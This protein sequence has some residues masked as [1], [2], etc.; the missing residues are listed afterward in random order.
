MTGLITNSLA[1]RLPNRLGCAQ[2]Y[3][4]HVHYWDRQQQAIRW[5]TELTGII[6]IT[7]ERVLDDFS[8]AR[9]KFKPNQGD[10]C[11]GKI[12]PI[13]NRA[14]QLVS[15]GL[16]PWAH[17]LS[18]YR[19]GEL[20]WQG[21]LFSIDELIMPDEATESITLVARDFIGWLDRRVVHNDLW[22]NNNP[23]H[24]LGT[25]DLVEIAEAIVRDAFGPDDPGVLAHLVTVLSGRRSKRTIRKWE[26]RSGDELRDI[27]RTGLDITCVGRAIKIKG[28]RRDETETTKTLR[29]QDFRSGIEIRVIGSEAATA[30]VTVG[31]VETSGDPNAPI[32]DIPPAKAYVTD[33]NRPAVDPFFGLIENWTQQEG[34]LDVGYLEWIGRQKI[35]EGYPP[36][37]TLSV[38]TDSGLSPEA[39]V[40]IHHL[41]PGTFFTILVQG[42]CRSLAQYMRLSHVRV[43][44]TASSAEQVGVTFIPGVLNEDIAEGTF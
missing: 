18:I 29:A 19:D 2:G 5:Y 41:V 39:P 9:V 33:P 13:L 14:G 8:E 42:T 4:V 17:E 1:E 44:W 25:Y 28:A 36:P 32:E 21:P 22:L 15:P 6:E 26:A 23:N 3:T 12:R 34:V 38:P 37:L 43:S 40:S 11:C 10:D 16:W 7:W 20:V 30:G 27:A 35:A 24:P 31:G